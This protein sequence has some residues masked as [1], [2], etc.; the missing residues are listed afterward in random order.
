MLPPVPVSLSYVAQQC[1]AKRMKR[2][3]REPSSCPGQ[4]KACLRS[5]RTADKS[6]ADTILGL[7][8]GWPGWNFPSRVTLEV[9]GGWPRGSF[10]SLAT[11]M[12]ALSPAIKGQ[13]DGLRVCSE[14][15]VTNEPSHRP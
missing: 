15:F 13:D 14:S 10:C 7:N 11:C 9:T 12:N 2:G 1:Q 8:V 4:Y 3:A 5:S 6:T